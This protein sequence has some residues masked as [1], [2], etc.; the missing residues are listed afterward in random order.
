MSTALSDVMAERLRQ[1]NE[2]GWTPAHDDAH[3]NGELARAAACYATSAVPVYLANPPALWPWDAS[4]WKP[5]D[6]RRDLIR[7]G[8]LIIA[9]LDRLQRA[10]L[11]A[12]SGKGE[13][14]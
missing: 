11:T 7:A 5:K 2:E 10:A 4:W 6:A 13:G 1:I 12:G 8:A 9:E 14:T 3:S